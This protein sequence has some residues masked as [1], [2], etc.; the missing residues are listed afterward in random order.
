MGIHEFCLQNKGNE[1]QFGSA[2]VLTC[3]LYL[4]LIGGRQIS[5]FQ[6]GI[7]LILWSI[8]FWWGFFVGG[9]VFWLIGGFWI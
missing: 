3:S 8:Y 2:T 9:V 7:F 1:C 5:G 4:G 6:F